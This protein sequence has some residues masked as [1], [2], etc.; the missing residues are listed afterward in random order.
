MFEFVQT[1]TF[2]TSG[3]MKRWYREGPTWFFTLPFIDDTLKNLPLWYVFEV[4]KFYIGLG[5]GQLTSKLNQEK[6]QDPFKL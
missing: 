1:D 6:L 2:M 3:V 4:L 5:L